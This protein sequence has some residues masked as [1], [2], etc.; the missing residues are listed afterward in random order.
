MAVPT[1][2]QNL[3]PGHHT[4]KLYLYTAPASI[5]LS[6]AQMK[7]I[8]E[9]SQ[10]KMTSTKSA[11]KIFPITTFIS[12]LPSNLILQSPPSSS[13]NDPTRG[14]LVIVGDVHGMVK[15]LESLLDKVGFDK[16]NGDHLILA[17]D[18]VNKGPD[19]AGVVDLAIRLGASAVRG[20]HDNAVLHAAGELNATNNISQEGDSA[21]S[22]PAAELPEKNVGD[23][24]TSPNDASVTPEAKKKHGPATYKTASELSAHHLDW[25]AA[26]PLILRIK[27]PHD[28]TSS[29]GESLTVVHAGLVPNIP[30]EKQDPHAVM[31]MRS[32][33]RESGD[34]E[35]FFPSED[36]G[37][38]GWVKEW[39]Q[40]QERQESKTTVVFGHDAK[41][42]L[43]L[44]KYTIG[45]D[46]ACLYG[47]K[48][49]AVV[50]A[51]VDERIQHQIVQVD[52]IDEPVTPSVSVKENS[53]TGIE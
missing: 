49:S 39:D 9:D 4:A 20:N 2:V 30:L 7:D 10:D 29:F 17:G 28:L 40:W 12:D 14:H 35:E 41:R 1:T 32:L 52:C 6:F 16:R 53:K 18:L 51:A 46:S 26:L 43:Q 22:P 47:H 45:L 21:D 31:H 13:E 34:G 19:S 33:V 5:S 23:V 44:G 37:E 42:R 27:L 25:L 15:S 38:E 24:E 8:L 50:F 48:L 11:K 36:P 3:L